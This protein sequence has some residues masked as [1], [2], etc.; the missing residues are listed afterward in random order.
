MI[1][2]RLIGFDPKGVGI[3]YRGSS[4]G[5]MGSYRPIVLVLHEHVAV[6]VRTLTRDRPGI[7][8][9]TSW[10]SSK[11]PYRHLVQREGGVGASSPLSLDDAY[12]T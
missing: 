10:L 2:S 11:T 5:M 8:S 7:I 3:K 6:T 4:D 1:S 12:R 9:L